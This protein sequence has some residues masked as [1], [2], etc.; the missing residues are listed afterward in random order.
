MKAIDQVLLNYTLL[1]DNVKSVT[2]RTTGEELGFITETD[3]FFAES[4]HGP[5][6]EGLRNINS[7]ILFL[8]RAKPKP[9]KKANI[10]ISQ[11]TLTDLL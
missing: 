8:L 5:K 7:A 9:V 1:G 11:T 6:A 10:H 4:A 2:D 3:T